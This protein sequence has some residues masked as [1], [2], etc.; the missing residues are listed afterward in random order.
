MKFAAVAILISLF[1]CQS[2]NFEKAEVQQ[3]NV[4]AAVHGMVLFGKE[5]VYASHIPM[6]HV[7]H[8]WQL[9][10]EVSLSHASNDAL[11]AYRGISGN[12][13]QKL[14]TFQPLPYMLPQLIEGK[15]K[16]VT[17]TIFRG[18]F[19][20][21]G[22]P[23]LKNATLTVSKIV[24][25]KPL[26]TSTAPLPKLSYFF[27]KDGINHGYLIHEI[28]APKNFDSIVE[29]QRTEGADENFENPKKVAIDRGDDVAKRVK[30]TEPVPFTI[31][32]A[33][34]VKSDFYC[35]IGPDFVQSCP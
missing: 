14:V 9:L 5:K 35:L 8:D 1:G 26:K 12:G 30:I 20:D 29:V 2:R 28:T 4:P 31:G 32:K 24:F 34:V 10:L 3:Q 22:V 27:L 19:E 33:F 23:I 25:V 13:A 16:T 21:G 11:K 18:N 17:G 15:I 7:P 6:Y